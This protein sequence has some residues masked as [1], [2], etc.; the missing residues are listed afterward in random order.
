[1][2]VD[3]E[4]VRTTQ[5]KML[6]AMVKVGRRTL[7]I[8]EEESNSEG[9]S[10]CSASDA[11]EECLEPWVDWIRRATSISE[12]LA[13]KYGICDWVD[14]Q[15][16]R[17]WK[18]AGHTARRGDGRWSSK[19]LQWLPLRGHRSRGHPVKRWSDELVDSHKSVYGSVDWIE[20]ALDRATWS[21]LEDGFVDR[22][23]LK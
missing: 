2:T 16:R 7:S 13:S 9:S 22:C 18:L 3:R 8:D 11:S 15:R 4:L 14:E 20:T 21:L 12:D 17:K 19:L 5:S 1:M 10:E 23:R 6:R